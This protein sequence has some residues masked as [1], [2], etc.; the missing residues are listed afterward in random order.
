MRLTRFTV[1]NYR[2][3]TDAYQISVHNTTVFLGKNNEGKTNLIKALKLAMDIIHHVGE[4]GRKILPPRLY[5]WEKDFPIALQNNRRLKHKETNFR[6]D[7]SLDEKEVLDFN[8]SIGSS[9]NGDLSIFIVIKDARTVSITMPKRGK[10]TTSLTNKICEISK[11]VNEHTNIQFIS[12]IRSESDAYE[13]I[14]ELIDSEL[15]TIN[16][17]KYLEAQNYIKESQNKKLQ[18]LS[19]RIQAQLSTFIPQ[20]KSIDI[21]LEERH[22]LHRRFPYR[23]SLSVNIDDGV[24]TSLEYKGDG[25]K[26]LTT[27]AILSQTDAE[28]R[29]IV[30]DEPE[31]HLHPAAIHYLRKA[32]FDLSEKNQVIISTHSPIFVNR[33]N[34]PSNIIVENGKAIPANRIDDI[35]K[36]LGVMMSDNLAYSNYVIVVEGPTDKSILSSLCQRDEKLKHLLQN[37]TK[38]NLFHVHQNQ[39]QVNLI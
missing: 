34:T 13:V 15:S 18:I 10:N 1:S 36:C 20:I 12:A 33:N 39:H 9:I 37:N 27:M 2:S 11:F 26:S 35:R 5:E 7:F 16:D 23:N 17:E 4:T 28:G 6:L 14:N 38:Q 21:N 19:N 8:T 22:Y 3:I 31:A 24:K 30:V 25:I 32:L 29:I